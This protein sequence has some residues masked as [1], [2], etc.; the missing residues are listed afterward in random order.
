[1]RSIVDT[2]VLEVRG[3]VTGFR[4][5]RLSTVSERNRDESR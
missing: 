1:M 5:G 3:E 2:V 4:E